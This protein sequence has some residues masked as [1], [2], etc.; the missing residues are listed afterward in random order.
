MSFRQEDDGIF[1]G[2]IVFNNAVLNS[3]CVNDAQVGVAAAIQASKM[4]HQHRQRYSQELA[5]AAST[6]SYVIHVFKG[7]TGG[8]L[9]FGCGAAVKPS[10][11]GSVTMNLK[12]GTTVILSSA[13]TLNSA[14]T[15]YGV[16][17]GTVGTSAC[18]VGD[19]LVL[20]IAASTGTAG[21]VGTGVFAFVDVLEDYQ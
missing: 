16:A 8:V 17:L 5:T 11:D 19:V 10:G 9:A 21:A 3:A 15:N 14:S 20:S 4:R 18:T 2:D 6:G 7:A 1:T 13:M 12:R